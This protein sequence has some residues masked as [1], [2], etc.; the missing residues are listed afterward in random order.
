DARELVQRLR[1]E[2]APGWDADIPVFPADAKG[3][4]TRVA[5]GKV[6]NAL[7]AKVPAL[8]G[9]S[10]DLDPSTY[11]GLKELGDFQ[12]PAPPAVHVQG[13]S[14]R[15]WSYSGRNINFC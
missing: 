12:A 5:S 6:M 9:G 13:S 4:A 10:A 11:T 3:I 14:G 2:L 15:A 8:A 1:G 7:A